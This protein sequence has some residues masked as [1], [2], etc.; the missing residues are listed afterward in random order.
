[1]YLFLAVPLVSLQSAI[2]TFTGH[3]HFLEN[4]VYF[5]HDKNTS[6]GEEG[7]RT[8]RKRI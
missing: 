1:M 3:N 2:V 5:K 6:T 4:I 8:C 7:A